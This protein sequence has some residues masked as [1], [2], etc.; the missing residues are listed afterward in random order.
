MATWMAHLRI[1]ENLLGSN[2]NLDSKY[3]AYGSLAPDCGRRAD[4]GSG[5]VPPKEVSHCVLQE[6]EHPIFQDLVFY[7]KYLPDLTQT[8]DLE[9]FSFLLAYFVHLTV[10]GL[11]YELIAEASR[12]DFKELIA[13]KGDEAWWIMKD[14]WYGLD[15]HHAIDDQSSL[16]WRE[17]VPLDEFPSFLPFQE[18]RALKA[19]IEFI[20]GFYSHPP[21]DLIER[22]HFPYLNQTTMDRFVSEATVLVQL[23]LKDV[24]AATIPLKADCSLDLLPKKSLLPY[25][26]P[27]GDRGAA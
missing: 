19:Q 3:F 27:L 24:E 11:W 21:L 17:I 14:D 23:V 20:Q 9:R 5:F 26:A 15:V 25:D 2:P 6:G 1:A 22:N 7:R 4:D 16:F 18:E 13:E 12:R 10:D 8:D